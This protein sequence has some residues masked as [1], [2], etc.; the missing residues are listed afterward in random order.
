MALIS[1]PAPD[2]W[3][4]K[5]P[6]VSPLVRR[7]PSWRTLANTC[8]AGPS[9]PTER[10]SR[11]MPVAVIGPAG[12]SF[13]DM[14]QLSE[15]SERNL[16]WLKLASI[17]TSVPS[18]P[19]FAARNT[20]C[21]G[22]SKRFSCPTA[23]AT[24]LSLHAVTARSTSAR[25]SESGFSQNTC[26]PACAAA[27]ICSVCSVCGVQSTTA[28]T[29]G[30]CSASSKLVSTRRPSSSTGRTSTPHTTFSLAL[31]FS[32]ATMVRPHQPR[33]TTA[34][35]S[36]CKVLFR[37]GAGVLH[38]LAPALG[39]LLHEAGEFARRAGDD[40]DA[41]VREALLHFGALHRLDHRRV[42]P[43]DDGLR[44]A[45]RHEDALPRAAGELGVARFGEGRRV[46]K[47]RQAL[48]AGHRDQAQASV[49]HVV[50]RRGRGDEHEVGLA[51][52]QPGDR[53][54]GAALVGHVHH[55]EAGELAEH[56]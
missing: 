23:S 8:C 10:S 30:S 54:P 21:T 39:F 36:G 38:R 17:C 43:L 25:E 20:S 28:C 22:G 3:L 2:L 34:T 6:R 19:A 44:R 5:I 24:R 14:R 7:L 18:S 9:R 41:A 47:G 32:S 4:T 42:E 11:W 37:R 29:A 13:S 35:P 27:T 31:S 50:H 45:G 49:L 46:G 55:V 51:A 40:V 53:R 1:E 52:H 33:P 16:S 15:V 48:G 26:F 56:L 12:A